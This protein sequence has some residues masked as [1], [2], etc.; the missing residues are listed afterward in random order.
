[1][2][3]DVSQI[4][5][6]VGLKIT[7]ARVA[8]LE[9]FIKHTEPVNAEFIIDQLKKKEMNQVTVYRN[10]TSLLEARIIKQ[11]DLRQ[12]S[13]YYELAN[14]HH[15]HLV[16]TNCGTTEDFVV[17][18]VEDITKKVLNNSSKFSAIQQHSLELFG[19]CKGC[20]KR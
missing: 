6:E 12:N 7:P 8:V 3:N 13:T 18:G 19:I 2:K 1:M 17:C 4:L 15:H 16:C 14:N 9:V 11:V 20:A 5:K 10:L